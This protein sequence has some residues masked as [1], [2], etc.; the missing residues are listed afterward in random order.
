MFVRMKMATMSTLGQRLKECRKGK[1]TQQYVCERTGIS[2]G[3]LSELENDK[4]PTSS[5]V[6]HLAQL[7]GVEALW[8]AEGKGQKHRTSIQ[9]AKL[10]NNEIDADQVETKKP[11]RSAK[12]EREIEAL[13]ALYEL[14]PGA[15]RAAITHS[16]AISSRQ[17]AK[18]RPEIEAAILKLMSV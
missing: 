10:E 8:L 11:V 7:Y 16:I 3:T 4:Y 18:N 9:P 1:Y 14:L 12:K 5:F 6:P 2:Q 17:Y 13:V 15:A